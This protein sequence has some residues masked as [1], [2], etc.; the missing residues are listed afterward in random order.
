M[1]PS[2]SSITREYLGTR[3]DGDDENQKRPWARIDGIQQLR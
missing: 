2:R 1:D 3:L